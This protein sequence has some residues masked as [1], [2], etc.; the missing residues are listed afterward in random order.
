MTKGSV[1]PTAGTVGFFG[2]DMSTVYGRN[3]KNDRREKMMVT[4][5][6]RRTKDMQAEMM[7]EK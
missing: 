1:S 3:P 5:I 2:F 4:R 6:D 7:I